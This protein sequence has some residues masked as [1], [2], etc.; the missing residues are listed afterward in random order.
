MPACAGM[1]EVLLSGMTILIYYQ[2][3]VLTFAYGNR[4]KLHGSSFGRSG[5]HDCRFSVVLEGSLWPGLDEG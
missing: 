1:T 5:Q 4:N 3:L 2:C